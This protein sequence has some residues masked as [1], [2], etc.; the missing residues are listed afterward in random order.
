M[1]PDPSSN[2]RAAE[3]A[4]TKKGSQ[5]E[6]I[7]FIKQPWFIATIGVVLWLILFTIILIVVCKRKRKRRQLPPCYRDQQMKGKMLCPYVIDGR[8]C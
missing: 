7:E 1:K 8:F 4:K 5:N 2:P 3:D 6:I